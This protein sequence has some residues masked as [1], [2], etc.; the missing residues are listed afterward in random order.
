MYG[1]FVARVEFADEEINNR[2][3]IRNKHTVGLNVTAVDAGNSQK[4]VDSGH[5]SDKT[6]NGDSL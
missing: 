5:R 2:Q 6:I 4:E 3:Q 1:V